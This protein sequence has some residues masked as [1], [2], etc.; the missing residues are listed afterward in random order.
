MRNRRLKTATYYRQ[1]R[2]MS[3]RAIDAYKSGIM[4]AT[5]WS[6]KLGI[7]T[8]LVRELLEWDSW[9]HTGKYAQAT[10][11]YRLPQRNVL[12]EKAHEFVSPRKKKFWNY[13][14]INEE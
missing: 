12:L 10:D 5:Q 3:L 6:Q 8:E 11:F 4:P 7:S 14:N 9:H 13:V 1:G 2:G